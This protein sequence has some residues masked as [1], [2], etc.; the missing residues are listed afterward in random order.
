[1][2][3]IYKLIDKLIVNPTQSDDIG[4]NKA[5]ITLLKEEVMTNSPEKQEQ[6]LILK[7]YL[8]DWDKFSEA[9]LE[10]LSKYITNGERLRAV[11]Y[12]KEVTGNGLA[13]S[14][15]CLETLEGEWPKTRS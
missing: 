2:K 6:S 12:I 1:M 8:I 4:W 5:I 11:K 15:E 9:E 10:E 13:V 14:K 7:K 3:S